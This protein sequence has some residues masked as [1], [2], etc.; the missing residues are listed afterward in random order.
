MSVPNDSWMAMPLA[1]F[2]LETTGPNPHTDRIVTACVATIDGRNVE[3][4]NWLLNP[5]IDIPQGA[6][7]VHGITSEEAYTHGDDYEPGVL[8]IWA[9]L[10]LAWADGRIVAIFNAAFDITMMLSEME[11][12]GHQVMP[13]EIGPIVDPFVIDRHWDKR[14]KGKRKL[15]NV[16][17]HYNVKLGDAHQADADALAA[18]RLAWKLPR[19]YRKLADFTAEQLQAEQAMWHRAR[20]LDFIEYLKREGKA[21]DDVSITWPIQSTNRT[22]AAA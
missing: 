10:Q 17:A 22:E 9:A 8:S 15:E 18:A 11:R 20:Q 21:A 3:V 4:S 6:T 5:G 14:R 2:D 19:R 13:A 7:D 12:L 16:C 1:C